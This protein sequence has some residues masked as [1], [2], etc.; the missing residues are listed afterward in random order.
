[1]KSGQANPIQV[2]QSQFTRLKLG[3]SIA[4]HHVVSL[5]HSAG[6]YPQPITYRPSDELR[7]VRARKEQA[8]EDDGEVCVAEVLFVQ[9]CANDMHS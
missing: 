9:Q 1:M 7:S 2:N 8:R 6:V 4:D 5:V 3:V